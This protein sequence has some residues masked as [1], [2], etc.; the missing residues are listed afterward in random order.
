MSMAAKPALGSAEPSL[1]SGSVSVIVM[2]F[3]EVSSLPSVVDEIEVAL[4][5]SHRSYE[6]LII[7]DG[8]TDGTAELTD[9]LASGRSAVRVIHHSANRGIGEVYRSGFAAA[10]GDYVTFLPADG[11][12]P[13][14][15][16]T[17]FADR[18]SSVDLVLGYI[19]AQ[20]RNRTPI[21]KLLSAAEKTLFRLMFGRLPRFQGI[22]MFRRTLLHSLRLE[23]SGRGWGIL[24]EL[25]VKA[26]RANLP[27]V[28]APTPLRGRMAGT[29]K[30][31]N[32]KTVVANLQ[33]AL[34]I[35]RRAT[36]SSRHRVR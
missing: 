25:I 20:G 33:Q 13:A 28:S 10:R 27:I 31:N 2:A 19:P 17:E 26:S 11:Q 14:S 4:R 1:G 15:V 12:F 23:T 35:W 5:A 8:S 7:D 34:S 36:L 21:A 29:S 6:I 16:V 22:M 32:L 3:N 18:M 9:R 30:V 24:L